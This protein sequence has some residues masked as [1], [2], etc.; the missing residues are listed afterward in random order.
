MDK[1]RTF[2]VLKRRLTGAAFACVLMA[3]GMAAVVTSQAFAQEQFFTQSGG[4]GLQNAKTNA[5]L[6][7]VE[8]NVGDLQATVSKIKPFAFAE[9]G[10]CAD[11]GEKLRWD[12]KNWICEQETDPTVQPFAKKALPTCTGGAILGVSGGEFSCQNVGFVTSEVDPTVQQFAKQPLPACG[13]GQVLAVGSGNAL[14]CSADNQGVAKETDPTVQDFAKTGN[15]LVANCSASESLTMSG[16]HL[17]CKLDSGITTEVDPM[18]QSFARS[19]V[20]AAVLSACASGEILKAVDSGGTVVL[21]CTSVAGA[22]V[23][24]LALNDLRDVSVTNPAS[25]TVLMFTGSGWEA[26]D[27]RDP[28]VADWAKN[29]ALAGCGAGQVLSFDGTNLTCVNDAGGSAQPLTLANLGDVNV[30]GKADGNLLAYN[31]GTSKWEDLA[32]P[33]CSTGQTLTANGTTMSCVNDAG[34]ASDPLDLVELGDVRISA[35]SNLVPSD[36]DLLRWSSSA[37]RWVAVHDMLSVSQTTAKW[38]YFNGTD[39]VCDRGAPL[40]CS[41]GEVMK[42]SDSS[43]AFSCVAAASELGLGTMASQD[44][45]SVAITGGTINGTVIGGSN[46]AAGTFTTMTATSVLAG[47]IGASGL[48]K[49]PSLQV[50]TGLVQGDLTV[51]GNLNVSGSQS[52]DGVTFAN[53]GIQLTGALAGDQISVTNVSVSQNVSVTGNVSAA[54]YIGD[55]SGLT[56]VVAAAGNWYTMINIPAQVQEVSNSGAIV[57]AGISATNISVTDALSAASARVTGDLHVGGNF[58]VSGSQSIDGVT[59]ANGGIQL[60]GG[61]TGDRMDV[62]NVS[63]SENVSVTGNVSA[64]KFIGDGSGLSGVV[65]SSADW[66][67]LTRI[68][69]QVQAVSNSGAIAL[70]G[71]S[72]TNV[73]VTNNLTVGGSSVVTGGLTAATG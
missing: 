16:G 44:A 7:K 14:V 10:T 24:V 48:I 1:I 70:S 13:V 27:E 31:A 57:M 52:I 46:A 19:D 3:L 45:D 60:T 35:G 67:A 34:G 53:G 6:S 58:Y 30:T 49:A 39:V 15:G 36:K 42:W 41:S 9:L 38:C 33:T 18:V 64:N 22:M 69:A 17:T 54:K 50:S 40:E 32:V 43:H 71:V 63:A 26:K 47:D 8:S 72:S 20:S 68:P 62:A 4:R 25:N 2:A 29:K 23:N 28:S 56:G 61:M 59:F 51:T 12:G 5:R 55:G 65:A 66:Y 37:S 11:D 73:S 21:Q